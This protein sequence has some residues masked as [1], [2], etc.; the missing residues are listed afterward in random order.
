MIQHAR[1][2]YWAPFED[3]VLTS[4]LAQAPFALAFVS[5][6]SLGRYFAAE[7]PNIQALDRAYDTAY[8]THCEIDERL[9]LSASPQ[10]T[11]EPARP[12]QDEADQGCFSCCFASADMSAA[13]PRTPPPRPGPFAQ[14]LL[15]YDPFSTPVGL[16]SCSF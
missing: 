2:Q 14:S 11:A 3:E 15:R 13:E 8:L 5:L 12:A 4:D 1:A 7:L 6:S 16:A 9:W 10:V